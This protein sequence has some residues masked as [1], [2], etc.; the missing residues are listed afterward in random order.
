MLNS[1]IDNIKKLGVEIKLNTRIDDIKAL[2][3]NGYNA[4]FVAI[5]AHKGD[6]MGIPGEDITGVYDAIDFLREI[7]LGKQI[8][9]GDKVAVIG[10]GNSAIDAARVSLRK[11]AKD[12]HILY[13]REKRDMPAEPE[14]ID[15]AEKEGIH[16]R[17]LTAPSK[18]L[19]RINKVVG[20]EC[21]RMG[22]GEFDRSGRK[23][24]T[25]IKGSEYT[26]KF[27]TVIEA[28]GQRPDM[29]FLQ[30]S[31]INIEKGRMIR[32]DRRTLATDVEGIFAGGDALTG[33]A[34]VIEAVAAG[35]RAAS[36]IKRYLC[37]EALAPLVDR[38]DGEKVHVPPIPPSN[39][40]LQQKPRVTIKETSFIDKG[41][42]FKEP[43]LA[44]SAKEAKEEAGRC[45]RCDLET[46]E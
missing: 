41:A 3:K 15:A 13:R 46:G 12:V 5:G 2:L 19:D 1:E 37:G 40:E 32:A 43:V 29:D 42:P 9:V 11:G 45:L 25:P 27:D 31:G 4:V 10:G 16:I 18:V 36:S 28:I 33:P 17:Y 34:T 14:E 35:Q 21:I 23:I 8:N 20:L 30:S 44:Y 38:T 22:L 39:E 7:N 26:M 24:P 6:K